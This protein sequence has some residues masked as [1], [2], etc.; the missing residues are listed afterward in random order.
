M[1]GI[2]IETFHTLWP[3]ILIVLMMVGSMVWGV[4]K[5]MQ[6]VAHGDGQRN[7]SRQVAHS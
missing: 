2:D 5:V 6:L 1:F 7:T 4:M 3:S